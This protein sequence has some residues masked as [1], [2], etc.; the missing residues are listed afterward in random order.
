MHLPVWTLV[1][2]VSHQLGLV[3]DLAG[4]MWVIGLA[5]L[6]VWRRRLVI[7]ASPSHDPYMV[8]HGGRREL[9]HVVVAV[10]MLL[11]GLLLEPV[12]DGRWSL[13]WGLAV[14]ATVTVFAGLFAVETGDVH[15]D[16]TRMMGDSGG[17]WVVHL[18][19]LIFALGS[20]LTRRPDADDTL[21]INRADWVS[22]HSGAFPVRDVL[23]ADQVF[24]LTRAEFP[25]TAY[26]PLLGVLSAWTRVPAMALFHLVAGPV[27]AALAVWALWRLFV[28]IGV[29][30]PGWATVAATVFLLLNGRNHASLGNFSFARSWQGKSVLLLVVI[31]FAARAGLRW[32]RTGDR[33]ALATVVAAGV[34]GVGLSSSSL[35][36]MPVVLASAVAA[37]CID[38]PT[39]HRMRRLV[40]GGAGIA[41]IGVFAVVTALSSGQPLL[42][43][44]L[45][46]AWVSPSGWLTDLR[47]PPDAN[48]AKVFGSGVSM[49]IVVPAIFLAPAAVGSR[50]AR[51][52]LL[53]SGPVSFVVMYAPGVLDV[54]DSVSGAS[55]VLW[56][57][58]WLLHVPLAIGAVA[59]MWSRAD[60]RLASAWHL[61]VPLALVLAMMGSDSW[62][63]NSSN[64]PGVG[65]VALDLPR[66][67]ADT[68]RMVLDHA[69]PG[70]V[71][72]GTESVNWA[73]SSLDSRVFTVSPRGRYISFLR[74]H[75]DF[76]ADARITVME[77]IRSG[78]SELSPEEV[79]DALEVLS[80][81]LLCVLVRD[82][83]IEFGSTLLA[84]GWT[85]VD[86]NDDCVLYGIADRSGLAG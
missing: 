79:F 42:A 16:R 64:V 44:S 30:W 4:V 29:R 45:G 67:S 56:R 18:T 47:V 61:F 72:S 2:H 9:R 41:P 3:R 54:I 73:V 60:R 51:L 33:A 84:A 53:L 40:A 48:F 49:A 13:Y 11:V 37:G 14:V 39:G 12:R 81:D 27:I 76:H 22:R 63:L 35:F 5:G 43:E 10:A 20:L 21:L 46:L 25:Q 17:A 69:Q 74:S 59:T 7:P 26:E 31:P 80:V 19:A 62:V 32:G 1:F 23:F 8:A 83:T 75:P 71:I 65:D 15:R 66:G 86:A 68:A 34:A 52:F 24:P 28:E 77:S 78:I 57:V 6:M 38:A 55:S 85:V 36:L 50:S 82:R 70:D 58:A